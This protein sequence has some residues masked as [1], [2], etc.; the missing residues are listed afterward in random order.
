MS[1]AAYIGRVGALAVALGVGVAVAGTA[2]TAWAEPHSTDSSTDSASGDSG[3][4]S[5]STTGGGDTD[6][7]ASAA[8]GNDSG[9]SEDP[10]DSG[11]SADED[12]AGVGSAGRNGDSHG[13][14]TPKRRST[15]Q[16]SADQFDSQ[17]ASPRELRTIKPPRASAISVASSDAE[18]DERAGTR[19]VATSDAVGQSPSGNRQV[20]VERVPQSFEG[21]APAPSTPSAPQ[22]PEPAVTRVVSRMSSVTGLVPLAGGGAPSVPAQS[23][24]QLALMA[25]YRQRNEQTAINEALARSVN[26]ANTSLMAAAANRAPTAVPDSVTVAED[27]ARTITAA[28]L[29]VNDTDPDGDVLRVHSVSGTFNG[30]AVL[31]SNGT[32]T[33]T[34]KANFSG[35][36]SFNYRVKDSAGLASVNTAKVT[37]TVNPVNDAPTAVADSATAAEDTARTFTVAQLVVNDTDPDGGALS[38][39]SVSG[40]TNGTAVLNADGTVTFTPNPNFSG[41]ASFDYRDKDS[42]GLA[43]VNTAKVTITVNQVNDAP[44]AVGDNVTVA[45]DTARTFTAAEVVG[46]DTDPEGGPLRVHSVSGVTNGTV[47]LNLNGTVTFTPKANYTGPASFDYRVR[48]ATGL[49]SV[50]TARVNVTVTPAND[51]PTAV[52]D[53]ATV[54]EDTARTFTVAE[55]VGNDTDP[56]KPYGD[57]L[58]VHSVSG[59]TNGTAVLNAN[60]TVTF[61]PYANYSGPASFSYRAKDAA[62]VASANSATV[63]VTVTPVDDAPTV[64]VSAPT[65][66]LSGV[67]SLSADA[68]DDVGVVGVQFLLNGNPIGAEDTTAPYGVS[69]NTATVANGTHIVTARARDAAGNA[70]TSAAVNVVVANGVP[71][72]TAPTVSLTGPADGSTVSGIVNLTAAASDN[73]GV[74]RVQFFWGRPSGDG[75][76]LELLAEDTTAPYGPVSWDSTAA[77]NGP[78]RLYVRAFDA[79]GNNTMR[80]ITVVVNNPAN[81]LAPV[82]PGKTIPRT[83][84]PITGAV[85]GVMNV[86]DPE[87]A[88]L[89]YTLANPPSRG[90]TVAFDQP[91]G[92]F[93]YVPSQAARNQAAGT[94]GLDY[95]TFGVS[96]SDGI[97]TVQT[98]VTVQV[99]ATL[100]PPTSIT[101]TPAA[102]GSGPSGVAIAGGYAYVINYDSNNVT[103]I[104]TITN[105]F[106]TNL[107]VGAGPLSV[108]ANPQSNRVYVSNSLSNTV[109]VID[110]TTNIVIGNPIPINVLPGSFINP[111]DGETVIEYPNRVTEVVASA[112][113]LYVNATDGRITVIDTTNDVNSFIRADGLGT[114]NDL[115]VSPDG[116]RLLGTGGTRLSV[117]ST[118]TMTATSVPVG[119]AWN[120]EL[121]RNE[122]INSVGNVAMS[123]D[124]KRAY[125]TFGARS[126][127]AVSVAKVTGAS[128]LTRRE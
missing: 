112:N 115:K 13:D 128:S 7:G 98:S 66:N 48:D 69:W 89:S 21:A 70:T 76:N 11:A 24:L 61:T 51:V 65:G 57:V 23:P 60:G 124:G 59:A 32:V 80:S 29:V 125:V 14:T 79:A 102:T 18:V 93:T 30:T 123:S 36:A 81:N 10:G 27:T 58:T 118:A 100:P 44:T 17:S 91:T 109:S 95:D 88:Q 99:A 28:E 25:A 12:G 42:A 126:P 62:G 6:G 84:D 74:G 90:G 110:A 39:H 56:D 92:V 75:V 53:S 63:S 35:T 87:Q 46:N 94:S 4:S 127:N 82:V 55:L 9:D 15:S 20:L 117:I 54:A 1:Y 71:D 2:G 108:A 73:V 31:N 119:T 38:V 85:T 8:S 67:V 83:L 5:S 77:V 40:A 122:Y 33:F 52:A 103:V 120:S 64:T 114:F 106:V 111:W 34:P 26:L 107:D 47:V 101:N 104:D 45:E 41:T 86:R 78:N 49:V 19:R 22:P 68:A 116:T 3:E 37:V 97:A 50:N 113:R 16:R 72:T 96:I 121:L 43:S 105:Q